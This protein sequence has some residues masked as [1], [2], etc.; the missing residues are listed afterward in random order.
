MG[1][2]MRADQTVNWLYG[3]LDRAEG[4]QR[5]SRDDAI[6]CSAIRLGDNRSP[7]NPLEPRFDHSEFV[8]DIVPSSRATW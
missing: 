6:R 3:P 2:P 8:D 4:R 7:P 5:S 1:P